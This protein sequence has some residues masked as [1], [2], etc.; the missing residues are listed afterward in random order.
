MLKGFTT[1]SFGDLLYNHGYL[2]LTSHGM[3]L[4]AG[5]FFD[6]F[7][8]GV[9]RQPRKT[10]SNMVGFS[11]PTHLKYKLVNLDH[12]NPPRIGMKPQKTRF[13]LAIVSTPQLFQF[14]SLKCAEKMEAQKKSIY[15]LMPRFLPRK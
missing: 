15:P 9:W 10:R 8:R 11:P 2:P 13:T 3:I 1:R 4:Q 7:W 12:V 6:F 14:H 5:D